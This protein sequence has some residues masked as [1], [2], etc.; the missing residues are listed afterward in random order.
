MGGFLG[1]W[2]G[3]FDWIFARIHESGES[4]GCQWMCVAVKRSEKLT[5]EDGFEAP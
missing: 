4:G 1:V 3:G 2:S 5:V